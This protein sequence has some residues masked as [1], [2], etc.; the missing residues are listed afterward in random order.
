MEHD[1]SSLK[2]ELTMLRPS[3]LGTCYAWSPECAVGLRITQSVF[4]RPKGIFSFLAGTHFIINFADWSTAAATTF[5][6]WCRCRHETRHGAEELRHWQTRCIM[7]AIKIAWI[8]SKPNLWPQSP[9]VFGE[10]SM[11]HNTRSAVYDV[12]TPTPNAW[13]RTI[14]KYAAALSFGSV[15]SN[16]IN[17]FCISNLFRSIDS[18]LSPN[19]MYQSCLLSTPTIHAEKNNKINRKIKTLTA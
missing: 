3:G 13:K 4:P 2:N 19:R 11:M 8:T 9:F 1:Y 14:Y 17:R 16:Q 15:H 6:A 7:P 5:R 12:R 10:A 18:I